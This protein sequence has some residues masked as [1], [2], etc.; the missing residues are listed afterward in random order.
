M[1]Y[2]KKILDNMLEAIQAIKKHRT[3]PGLKG[4]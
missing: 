2:L 1:K 3:G 4:R